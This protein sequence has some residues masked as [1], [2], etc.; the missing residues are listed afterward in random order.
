VP[1]KLLSSIFGMREIV[2]II[3]LT[4]ICLHCSHAVWFIDS[5]QVG[6]CLQ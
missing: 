6:W 4:H 3:C 1:N 5:Y 2:T